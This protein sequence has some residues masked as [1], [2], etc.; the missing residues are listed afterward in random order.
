MNNALHCEN[1][2][3]SGGVQHPPFH[4]DYIEV[5]D[6]TKN[7]HAF[8]YAG[9]SFIAVTLP[10]IELLWDISQ[11]L[12]R[13]VLVQQLLGVNPPTGDLDALHLFIFQLQLSFVVSH[14]YTHHVHQHCDR[15]PE[16]IT[17]AWTEFHALMTGGID[18]QAQE[19]DADAYAIY[20]GLANFLRGDGRQS[21]L[22]QLGRQGSSAIDAD[23][24]LLTC[25]LLAVTA[26]FCALWV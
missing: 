22:A 23:D 4:F 7:A 18:D 21:G 1:V 24:I 3:A 17:G 2:N 19:L 9:F 26:L 20:L 14:E 12:C 25:F 15:D 5:E 10:L 13:S 16:G 11:R 6:G 8:Q